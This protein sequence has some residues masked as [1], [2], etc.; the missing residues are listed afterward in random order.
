MERNGKEAGGR[1][2]GI[3]AG[4]VRADFS[5]K[6]R[7][8]KRFLVFFVGA[9]I[10]SLSVLP[11]THDTHLQPE[12]VAVDLGDL[13]PPGDIMP[14][15]VLGVLIVSRGWGVDRCAEESGEDFWG[16]KTLRTTLFRPRT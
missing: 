13:M 11:R 10:D 16:R 1:E 8:E 14:R 3:S 12:A 2:G 4:V 15:V 6:G 7:S 9:R 5:K